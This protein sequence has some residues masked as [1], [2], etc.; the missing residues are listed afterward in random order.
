MKKDKFDHYCLP[1]GKFIFS[2][3]ELEDTCVKKAKK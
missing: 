3:K 2:Q 1:N